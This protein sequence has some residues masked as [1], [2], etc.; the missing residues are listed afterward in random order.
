MSKSGFIWHLVHYVHNEEY[1]HQQIK[2]IEIETPIDFVKQ[3]YL[4]ERRKMNETFIKHFDDL[5]RSFIVVFH[6]YFPEQLALKQRKHTKSNAKAPRKPMPRTVSKLLDHHKEN[7]FHRIPT[8]IYKRQSIN[9][10]NNEIGNSLLEEVGKDVEQE[11]DD[12]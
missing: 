3:L 10:E 11:G 9:N 1:D 12:G 5:D 8:K 4:A 7:S 2:H 6:P